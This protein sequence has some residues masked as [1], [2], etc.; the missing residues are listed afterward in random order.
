M[1]DYLSISFVFIE[2][3]CRI[4]DMLAG[5]RELVSSLEPEA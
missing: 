4:L 3:E 5:I 1:L 2:N